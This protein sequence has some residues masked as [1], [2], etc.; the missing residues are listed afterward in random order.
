MQRCHQ[1]ALKKNRV[2]L[3]K[4]LLLSE[5]LEHMIEKDIIT[6]EMVEVIQAKPGSFSQNVE[7]LNLLPKRGPNA[8]SAFC[9]AL[10]E[11]RQ[12]HL[13]AVILKTASSLSQGIARLEHRYGSNLPIP[14]SE[15]CNSKRPRWI[16][17]MENSLD[18]GDGPL[19]PQV[20]YCTPKF[21]HDHQHLAYKLISEPRGLALI[22]SNVHFSSEKDLEYRAGGDVDCTSLEMLFKHLGYQVTVFHDQTAQEMQN[23]LER[24]SKMPDH[25]DVDSCIVAL[26][27]HGVEGGVYG[28]DG[29]LLQLQEAFRLF[30]NANCP[31][32][33]NKPKMFFIQACRGDETD[34][35]V[36]QQ[37]GKE[38]SDSPGCE[39]SD[40]NKEEN[41]KLRLPTCSDMICGYACLK[42]EQAHQATRRLC[43][44]H[45]IPPLQRNVRIL[46]H[47][48]P[49]PLPVPWLSAR[50]I[51]LPALCK[52]ELPK[53]DLSMD[54]HAFIFQAVT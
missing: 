17:P 38:W 20:K 18:N 6:A 34:R 50:K 12:Q 15:S 21:Y 25:R 19:I 1:E 24:F 44:R 16:E 31:N 23:A 32:L 35:G 2:L 52:G 30:D 14:I 37:D 53:L 51:T 26:L 7:F 49:G 3:A 9:E 42:G 39:E 8:F 27:S 47:A 43:P 29:K 33:Q 10:R 40:A 36:D 48:L 41:L 22:L 5:L 46:Q 11:T 28:S 4:Q 13:E 54:V 45:R